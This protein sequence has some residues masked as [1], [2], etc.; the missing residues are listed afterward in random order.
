MFSPTSV[1][2]PVVYFDTTLSPQKPRTLP[3][4]SLE[5]SLVFG[6]RSSTPIV[7]NVIE[8]YCLSKF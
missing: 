8:L 5:S 4:L 3:A 1:V 6:G 7:L 2:H